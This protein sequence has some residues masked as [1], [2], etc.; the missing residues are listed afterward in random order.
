MIRFG[1]NDRLKMYKKFY[2]ITVTPQITQQTLGTWATR[3]PS[4]HVDSGLVRLPH[5]AG[6]T[7][8]KHFCHVAHVHKKEHPPNAK[9]GT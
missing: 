1:Q 8:M 6:T 2:N 3:G 5:S 7:K 9:K 4:L